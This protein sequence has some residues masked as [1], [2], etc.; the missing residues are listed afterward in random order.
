MRIWAKAEIPAT[1]LGAELGSRRGAA[2][3]GVAGKA[4]T[5]R[6]RTLRPKNL[7]RFHQLVQ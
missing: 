5:I 6:N 4:I 7:T 1:V 2:K 3:T